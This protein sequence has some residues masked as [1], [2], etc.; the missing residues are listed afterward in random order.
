MYLIVPSKRH[1]KSAVFKSP[2]LSADEWVCNVWLITA[3]GLSTAR[4]LVNIQCRPKIFFVVKTPAFSM[5]L[6]DMSH[7]NLR[8]V[9]QHVVSERCQFIPLCGIKHYLCTRHETV[10]LRG[11]KQYLYMWHEVVTLHVVWCNT[12]SLQTYSLNGSIP[13]YPN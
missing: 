4:Q 13:S 3:E 6:S 7:L 1:F 11:M 9:Q 10:P 8:N 2:V 5:F 12:N